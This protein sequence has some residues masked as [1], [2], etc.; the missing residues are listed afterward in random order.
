MSEFNQNKYI[1]EYKKKR[2]IVKLT[3]ECSRETREEIQE[4]AKAAGYRSVTQYILSQLPLKTYTPPVDTR[5]PTSKI[6]NTKKE[7]E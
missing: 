3:V 2:G 1:A 4:L 5:R 6:W 7:T